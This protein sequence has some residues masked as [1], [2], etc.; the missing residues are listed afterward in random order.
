MEYRLCDPVQGGDF[1]ESD[2]V[3]YKIQRVIFILESNCAKSVMTQAKHRVWQ[4]RV[5]QI[6]FLTLISDLD[7]VFL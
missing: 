2:L 5:T 3:T 1:S 7:P 4:V 6:N